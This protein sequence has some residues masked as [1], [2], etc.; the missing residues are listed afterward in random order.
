MGTV[1]VRRVFA[2]I[3]TT[4]YRSITVRRIVGQALEVEDRPLNVRAV[5]GS[6]I[7]LAN[8]PANL[9]TVRGAYL[10]VDEVLPNFLQDFKANLLAKINAQN[11]TSFK[12]ADVTFGVPSTAVGQRRNTQIAVNALVSSGH[13]SSQVVYYDRIKLDHVI[14]DTTA[15]T[16]NMTGI[17]SVHELLPQ[18]NAFYKL[19]LVPA[20]VMQKTIRPG[21]TSFILTVAPT[22]LYFKPAT[23]V[24]FGS[25]VQLSSEFDITDL[26]GFS[27][28]TL[29]EGFLV[30]DLPGF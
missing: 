10:V 23:Q 16:L 15:I 14:K 8:D 25:G 17:T 12:V 24:Q 28:P 2:Q 9:R 18:I 3:L 5:R 6:Y 1:T 4:D 27:L 11:N 7:Q 30:K 13:S 26:D 20:D 19:A 22:S 21:E 29:A